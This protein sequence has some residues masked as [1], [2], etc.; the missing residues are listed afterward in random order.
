MKRN[1]LIKGIAVSVALSAFLTGCGGSGTTT[2]DTSYNSDNKSNISID[3]KA[4]D[5]YLQYAT[6]CLDLNQ[7][8][9][10]QNSEPNT[11]TD[12]NGKFKLN[13][14]AKVQENP[15]Y[16]KA[17]LLVYGGKDVD[18]GYDFVGKLLAPK[19][20]TVVNVTP[21]NTLV[22]KRL[23]KE[24]ET[25][26]NMDKKELQ[27]KLEEA[28]RQVAQALDL[29]EEKL[30]SDPVAELET[31]DERLMERALQL[32]KAVEAFAI[33]DDKKSE[34]AEEIYE[35]LAEGLDEMQE[36]DKGVDRLLDRTLQRAQKS[37]KVKT[38]LGGEEGLKLGDAAKGIAEN[39]GKGFEKFDPKEHQ[40]SDF[41]E[42][43]GAITTG[44]LHK[45]KVAIKDGNLDNISG[46]ISFDEGMFSR[47]FDWDKEYISSDLALLEIE[48]TPE[49]ISKIKELYQDKEK[50][51]P[52]ILFNKKELLG[53]SD[54]PQLKEIYK[55][56]LNYLDAQHKEQEKQHAQGANEV[57]K[58]TPPLT[59][60]IPED[61]GYGSVTFAENSNLLFQEYELQED[62]SFSR[63]ADEDNEP[64]YIFQNGQWVLE[65][66]QERYTLNADGS[67]TLPVWNE[68]AFLVKGKNLSGQRETFPRFNTSVTFPQN[69]QMYYIKIEKTD[70]SY[71]I[72]EPVKDHSPEGE[73]VLTSIPELI[74]AHCGNSW[75][76]GDKNGGI[77]FA[78]VQ[79]ENGY[80]CNTEARTGKLVYASRSDY[81]RAI[82]STI[83]KPKDHDA[84]TWEIK[85]L[86][87]GI[88]VLIVKP[89]NPTAFSHNDEGGVEYPIFTVKD[90]T[91]YRGD[92]EPKGEIKTIPAYNKT[93]FEAIA[94]TIT[95]N[96]D[97]IKDILPIF[98]KK[99]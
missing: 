89:S 61:K 32:H 60:Y 84:G 42:K 2:D 4:I 55:K 97:N 1:T 3:G 16:E 85:T 90:S 96:W 56:V 31:G 71:T 77:A 44:D 87:G 17:M 86:E 37:E 68:K 14:T 33:A 81:K 50:I 15:N 29:P 27:E 39:I 22:A 74:Q 70:D 57:V 25:N 34:R 19:E 51:R 24:L 41:L 48:A 26:Q 64:D 99:K 82:P 23:Q 12:A 79:T 94:S 10:C 78:G 69:A 67:I 73:K 5:G 93:A 38:L 46:Q 62:G 75:F 47:N 58:I 88:E 66:N 21:I 7:D 52:A 18:T 9:Y 59:V 35:A 72:N 11:Q 40:H 30:G 63:E 13:I 28:K 80:S 20:G 53:K 95:Q 92:M 83:V 91:L 45:V 54:D 36:G 65:D 76:I 6:V 43:I 98:D 8:G 49:L